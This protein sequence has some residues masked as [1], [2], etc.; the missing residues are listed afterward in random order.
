M[1]EIVIL[2]NKKRIE[3][4]FGKTSLIK[5]QDTLVSHLGDLL[6]IDV[7]DGFEKKVK[8]Y[9]FEELKDSILII[10]GNDNLFPFHRIKS[11]VDDGDG[12]ILTDNFFV[13]DDKDLLIPEIEIT[14]VPNSMDETID[15]FI[16]K[17]E[18]IFSTKNIRVCEKNGITAEIWKKASFEVFDKIKG[19]G[20]ILISPPFEVSQKYEFENF[21]GSF[22]FNLHGSDQL[23]GWYGQ[24]ARNSDY[25]EEYPLAL[26][27]KSLTEGI[28]NSFF[29]SEACFGGYVYNKKEKDS[30]VLSALKNSF[31]FCACS[32]A[33]AY[34]PLYPPSTE[35][36][37]LAKLFF[38]NLQKGQ[39]AS[40][41]FLNAKKEFIRL[42]IEK[43]K[44][45]DDDDKK[46]I[47]EFTLYG[48]PFVEVS[49]E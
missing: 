12:I 22:Y 13:C 27:P 30:I 49:Y 42:N 3:K 38:E 46:T 19:Q 44:Y 21:S 7:E 4:F 45:L 10:I 31:L 40:L 29:F 43:N 1:K 47:I 16:T 25:R 37:L 6:F 14:R 15:R 8:K 11:P 26:L 24:R 39:K 35:A 9:I 2:H 20:E 18:K 33:T 5:I 41:A 34:G 36:D 23:P 28:K 17:L 32:T 48:N